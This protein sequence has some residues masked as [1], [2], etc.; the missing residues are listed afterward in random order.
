M[1]LAPLLRARGWTVHL[2]RTNDLEVSLPGRVALA[3]CVNADLF[4]SLHF[5]GL[6]TPSSHTGVETYCTTPAG[7]LSTV[8]RRGEDDVALSFPNNAF[9][10]E[11]LRWACRIHRALLATGEVEDGGVRRARFIAVLRGQHRPAVLVEG[12]FLSNPEEAG[13]I[14]TSAYRQKLAEAVAKA[15]E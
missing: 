6:S 9:D 8:K 11:N 13:R 1:R 4:V 2:T 3:D 12:G 14:A 10:S 7:M 15:L 5:N